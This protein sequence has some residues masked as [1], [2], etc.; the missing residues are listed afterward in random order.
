MNV[1]SQIRSLPPEEIMSAF[2]AILARVPDTQV[3][4]T[5]LDL[6]MRE[7]DRREEE[8]R[9]WD[10]ANEMVTQF[11]TAM[12]GQAKTVTVDGE[13]LPVWTQPMAEFA[14]YPTGYVVAHA[15]KRWVNVAP[16][17]TGEE[18]DKGDHW[19]QE[20]QLTEEVMTDEE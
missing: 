11:H 15:K 12:A 17:P 2:K 20:E 9:A 4:P 18:P 8:R 16:Y 6:V 3:I 1:E 19:Q 5:A 13:E 10:R 14:Y 7:K